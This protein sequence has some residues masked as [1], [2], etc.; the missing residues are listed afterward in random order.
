MT[1]GTML[2]V[3]ELDRACEI[4]GREYMAA[5]VEALA[6]GKRLGLA[7]P[8]LHQTARLITAGNAFR[9]AYDAWRAALQ[10]QP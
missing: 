9:N 8:S 2:S 10:V 5:A 4:A 7:C 1:A 6:E 3:D